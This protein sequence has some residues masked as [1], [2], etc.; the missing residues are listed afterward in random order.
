MIESIHLQNFES[1]KDTLLELT[2]GLNVFVGDTDKGKSGSFRGWQWLSENSPGGDWMLPLYW[3]GETKVTSI[4][5]NPDATVQRI[6][7]K[8]KNHYTLNDGEPVNAGTSVP[9]EIANI[10]NVDSVNLQTQIER[11]FLMFETAGERGRILNRIAGLNKIETTLANA[12]RDVSRLDTSWKDEKATI[13]IKTK[14]LEEFA[15]LEN[16]E[17]DVGKLDILQKMYFNSNNRLSL[18]KKSLTSIEDINREIEEKEKLLH[19]EKLLKELESKQKLI[20]NKK[21]RVDMLRALCN[22]YIHIEEKEKLENFSGIEEKFDKLEIKEKALSKK[23]IRVKNLKQLL[24][25]HLTIDKRI[26][27]TEQDLAD[28]QSKLPN[29]CTECGREL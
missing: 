27:K 10:I 22:T 28:L 19:S 16:M 7:S 13:K 9:S 2:S 20:H 29:I 11:A 21:L 8:S 1:H 4:L 24:S 17:R 23:Q 25:N 26:I 12:K 15:D 3:D 6:R 5:S 14:E 18:L